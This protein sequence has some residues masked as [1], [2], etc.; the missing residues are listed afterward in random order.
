MVLQRRDDTVYVTEP[1]PNGGTVVAS[2][3]VKVTFYLNDLLGTNLVRI[4]NKD[5]QYNSL[6]SFGQMRTVP[7]SSPQPTTIQAPPPVSPISL[8]QQ[9]IPPTTR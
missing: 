3:P 6:T 1:H 2:H 5:V 8:P 9:Q 4:K 7:Q